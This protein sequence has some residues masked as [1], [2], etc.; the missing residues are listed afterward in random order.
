METDKNNQENLEEP[1]FPFGRNWR[2][3][4]ETID[5]DRIAEAER[6]LLKNLDVDTLEGMRFLD[7]GCGSG[8]F[9]LAARRLGA[10]VHSF[11]YDEDSVACTSI[12]KQRYGSDDE[13]WRIEQ[14]SV[15]DREYLWSLGSFDIV[16][17]WGVLHHTG[18]MWK[19]MEYVLL[20]LATSGKLFIA[21]YNDQGLLS[22]YWLYVKK[23]YVSG[24][25]GRILVLSVMVPYS[26]VRA[27]IAGLIESGNPLKRFRDYRRNRGMSIMHDW[28]DWI[29]GYPFEVA[30]PGDVLKFYRV[31]NLILETLITTNRSGCNQFVFRQTSGGADTS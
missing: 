4:L 17:S 15:L 7:A 28:I 24:L 22:R 25:V 1:R 20:P 31:H 5:E 12:L 21:L 6:S 19:A 3:F 30:K 16:Y 11:D 13:G 23:L 9:S 10:T 18:D 2:S 14:G 29:G 26:A 8:L 27:M